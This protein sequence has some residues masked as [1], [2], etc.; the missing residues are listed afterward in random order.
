MSP[1]HPSRPEPEQSPSHSQ[2]FTTPPHQPTRAPTT[3]PTLSGP[4]SHRSPPHQR[5]QQQR[6][7]NLTESYP[8][9]DHQRP[10]APPP[11]AARARDHASRDRAAS[12]EVYWSEARNQSPSQSQFTFYR[13]GTPTPPEYAGDEEEEVGGRRDRGSGG[14]RRLG[15]GAG[16]PSS[17]T[18]AGAAAA[19]AAAAYE[20][21][22]SIEP[23]EPRPPKRKVCGLSRR[24]FWLVVVLVLLAVAVGVGVGV[25]IGVGGRQR[26]GRSTITSRCVWN[27]F[28]L[29][30]PVS[31][32]D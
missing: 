29:L 7:V 18:A 22:R 15:S 1:P 28:M 23:K 24:A 6:Q 12:P 2:S 8:G 26:S 10:S 32:L 30:P 16:D 31:S 9:G 13:E 5:Q 19:E 25:G 27:L 17:A 4:S 20:T 21:A 11:A 14:G 3:S